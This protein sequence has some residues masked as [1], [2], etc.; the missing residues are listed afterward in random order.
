MI[1]TQIVI[2]GHTK[3]SHTH[4]WIHYAFNR[5]FKYMKYNTIWL[6]DKPL[7]LNKLKITENTLFITEGQSDNYIPINETCYYILHNCK[8]KYNQIP[9][10]QIISLQVYTNPALVKMKKFIK[11][12]I[13]YYK[14]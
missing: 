11:W 13:E 4:Y 10:N 3:S 14:I 9:N 2:W 1:F 6:P 7:S 12:Y 8:N 5:A